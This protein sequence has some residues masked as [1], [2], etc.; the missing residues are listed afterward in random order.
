M[1]Q[2]TNFRSP[3]AVAVQNSSGQSKISLKL[4]KHAIG[5]TTSSKT[6]TKNQSSVKNLQSSAPADRLLASHYN[7]SLSR[8]AGKQ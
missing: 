5:M 7:S 1:H 4:N 6:L 3:S 8:T 2:T